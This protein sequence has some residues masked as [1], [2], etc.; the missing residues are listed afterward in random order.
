MATAEE[1]IAARLQGPP[2]R[3]DW[4]LEWVWR[5]PRDTTPNTAKATSILAEA[6]TYF[7]DVNA[8]LAATNRMQAAEL[9]ELRQ[10]LIDHVSAQ[11]QPP[12]IVRKHK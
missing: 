10:V 12:V 11:P 1:L 5:H 3:L 8:G 6:V 2:E 9:Q 7:K 4:A